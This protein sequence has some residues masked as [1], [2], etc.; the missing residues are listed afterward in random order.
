MGDCEEKCNE[1]RPVFENRE[2]GSEM[3][4]ANL[5]KIKPEGL[6]LFR[7]FPGFSWQVNIL[8]YS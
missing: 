1:E 6:C 3:F 4:V 2:K 8:R 7:A 5:K